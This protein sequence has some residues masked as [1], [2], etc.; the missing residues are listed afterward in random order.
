MPRVVSREEWIAARQRR[1]TTPQGRN[2]SGPFNSMVDWVRPR[3]MYGKG[4]HVQAN[5][6]FTPPVSCC[7]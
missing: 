2:E 3:N 5:G 7:M 6:R 4:G 1:E